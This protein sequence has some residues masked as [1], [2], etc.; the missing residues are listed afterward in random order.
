M[1]EAIRMCEEIA[2]R[3]LDW[4][5]SEENR[6]GDHLWWISRPP[7]FERDYPDWSL[8]YSVEDILRQIHDAN[9]EH[10]APA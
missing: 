8:R 4:S 6:I 2:G 1:L 3:K 7:P 9:V 5:Y 10:W